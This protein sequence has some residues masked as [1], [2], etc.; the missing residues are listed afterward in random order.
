MRHRFFFLIGLGVALIVLMSS[1]EE[2]IELE[3]T[4]T[5]E[6]VVIEAL[7]TNEFKVHQVKVTRVTSFYETGPTPRVTDAQVAIQD[8]Q[9]NLFPFSHSEIE[10]GIYVSNAPFSGVIG[11]TYTLSVELDG[12]NYTASDELL[13]VTSI[14]SLSYEL[15]PADDLDDPDKSY[16]NYY[17]VLFYAREPQDRVDYYLFKFYKNG[18]LHN[19][20]GEDVYYADDKIVQ[21]N[22]DGFEFNDWYRRG[23]TARVEMFSLSEQAYEFYADLDLALNNDGGMFSPVPINPGSNHRPGAAGYFQVSAVDT[24]EIILPE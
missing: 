10:D 18:E 6:T 16:G 7:L 14:D 20:D 24:D 23:D 2:T 3:T 13:P 11:N 19:Y 21:E 12:V 4:L 17:K 1:C 8:N 9:G 22:I 15:V 5:E